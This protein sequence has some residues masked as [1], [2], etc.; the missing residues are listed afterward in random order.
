MGKSFP[1]QNPAKNQ[2]KQRKKQEK[3]LT[4]I[5]IFQYLLERF[6]ELF[7][8]FAGNVG[9]VFGRFGGGLG[10]S[11]SGGFWKEKPIRK[12]MI[13]G[14]DLENCY[15]L[16]FPIIS[17]YFLLFFQPCER[18][19]RPCKPPELCRPLSERD[20]PSPGGGRFGFQLRLHS[21]GVD[22]LITKPKEKQEKHSNT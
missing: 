9:D 20:R 17:H 6:L 18:P 2:E 8:R 16:L 15:R 22:V 7:E 21:S 12:Q 13:E 10:G 1:C 4:N 19:P 11:F 5:Y 3:P 14:K